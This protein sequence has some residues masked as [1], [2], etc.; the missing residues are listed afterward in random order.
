MSYQAITLN[1]EDAD[2]TNLDLA[3]ELQAMF[4]AK[5]PN[6]LA[7]V[8]KGCFNTP[9]LTTYLTDTEHNKAH[10]N[11]ICQNDQFRHSF[12]VNC[13]DGK[14][15]LD[16]DAPCLMVNPENANLY[17]CSREKMKNLRKP[18]GDEKTIKEWF[19]K[20]LVKRAAFI[21]LHRHNIKHLDV[22]DEKYFVIGE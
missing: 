3:L 22:I 16:F 4:N 14:F 20:F 8:S 12:M 10:G 11:G 15:S 18:C 19:A 7:V 2:M 9:F 21:A 13:E 6:Q 1:D 17:Y 5:F